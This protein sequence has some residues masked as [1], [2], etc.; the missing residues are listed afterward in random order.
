M[1]LSAAV[2]SGSSGGKNITVAATASTGTT[3]HDTDVSA[4]IYHRVFLY[5]SCTSTSGDTLLTVEFG[6]TSSGD[7]IIQTIPAQVGRVP[8]VENQI[9]VGTGAAARSVKAYAATANVIQ[10]SG[11]V[12]KHS[13]S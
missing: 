4:T 10:L 11:W 2:L 6:G 13:T 12:N 8:I 1:A 7:R 3:V 5:G 9:L